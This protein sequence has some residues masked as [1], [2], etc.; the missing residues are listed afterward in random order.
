MIIHHFGSFFDNTYF[1]EINLYK[2]VPNILLIDT[3]NNIYL[4]LMIGK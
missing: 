2:S 3:N 1:R 4:E